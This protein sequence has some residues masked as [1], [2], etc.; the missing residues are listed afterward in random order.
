[1]SRGFELPAHEESKK[2]E[3]GIETR[4][5]SDPS[6]AGCAGFPEPLWA[7]AHALGR[8]ETLAPDRPAGSP[9]L[10]LAHWTEGL[11]S[12]LPPYHRHAPAPGRRRYLGHCALVGSRIADH[13]TPLHRT[14][15]PDER[16][17]PAQAPITQN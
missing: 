3:A 13:H 12:H 16:A 5:G 10:S 8:G 14:G 17:V 2:E 9:P 15:P 11:A 1:M 7:A 4:P 6:G